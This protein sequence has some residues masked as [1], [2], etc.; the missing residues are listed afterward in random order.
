MPAGEAW[1]AAW[2]RDPELPLYDRDGFH[3]S[4]LGSCLAALAVYQAIA[5]PGSPAGRTAGRAFPPCVPRDIDK[6]A[7]VRAH[8]RAAATEAMQA[9]VTNHSIRRR[10]EP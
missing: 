5:G 4:R 3:P 6:S 10:A 1:R 2:R 7:E 9:T 8:L